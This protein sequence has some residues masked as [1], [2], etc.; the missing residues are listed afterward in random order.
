MTFLSS[1]SDCPVIL[2]SDILALS[3]TQLKQTILSKQSFLSFQSFFYRWFHYGKVL[4]YY[5]NE[6]FVIA[7]HEGGRDW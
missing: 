3:N 5:E 7:A 6:T 1:S 2:L 4:I